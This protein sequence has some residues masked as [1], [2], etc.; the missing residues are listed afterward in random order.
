MSDTEHEKEQ[1]NSTEQHEHLCS[2]CSC[3]ANENIFC[4][5]EEDENKE[6]AVFTREIKFLSA[7][8]ILFVLLILTEEFYSGSV[9]GVLLGSAFIAL[10]LVCGLPVLR[11][12]LH[13]ISKFDIFNEFTLMGAATLSAV[14][15]GEMSATPPYISQA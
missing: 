5:C 11:S 12:A 6:K 14:A 4:E 1:D 10:Y 7:A 2:C 9:N 13:A 15:I 8:A 3:S